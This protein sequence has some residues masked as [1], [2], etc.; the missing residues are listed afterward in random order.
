LDGSLFDVPDTDNNSRVFGYPGSRKGTK[1]AFPKTRLVLLVESGTHLIVDAL[2]GPYKIGERRRAIQLLRSVGRGMLLMWDRGLHSYR[3]VNSAIKR[4]AHILGRV[5]ANVKFEVVKVFEDGSYL[6]W[7]APDRKSKKKGAKRIKVRVIEYLIQIEGEEVLYRLITDLMDINKFSAL[8][9]AQEYHTR[10][11]IE[12]TLDELKTHLNG[13]KTMIRSKNPRE[14]V[15]EIYGW[16][17]AHYCIRA[18]MLDAATEKGVSPLR[19]SFTGSLKVIRRAVPVCQSN[20]EPELDDHYYSWMV[21]EISD[22][23]IPPRKNR[24][25]PRVVKKSRS[26]FNSCKPKYRGKGTILKIPDYQICYPKIA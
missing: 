18:T 12:N 7:I 24:S 26:K 1:A 16:L 23:I 19:I 22:L 4:K 5:P 2:I 11:E 17:I 15:Q 3:M 13:R 25:N 20:K 6:S 8:V 14:V 10:G 9:L 21:A